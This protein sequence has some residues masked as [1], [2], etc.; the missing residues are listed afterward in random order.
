MA[1]K[2]VYSHAVQNT[3]KKR[4]ENCTPEIDDLFRRMFDTDPERR[5]TFSDIRR[6]PVFARHFP[7]IQ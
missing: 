3:Q 6:H 5:I 4:K 7:I 1:E 2:F